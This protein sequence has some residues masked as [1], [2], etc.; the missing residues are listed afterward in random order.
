MSVSL[1]D[2]PNTR[3]EFV[4]HCRDCGWLLRKGEA[5]RVERSGRKRLVCQNRDQCA[6]RAPYAEVT[7]ARMYRIPDGRMLLTAAEA[8]DVRTYRAPDGR[9]LAQ[10]RDGHTMSLRLPDWWI[11]QW[12]EGVAEAERDIAEHGLPF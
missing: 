11:V 7:D 9:W 5:I 8:G 12:A 10:T 6:A 2:F 1:R 4:G 3:R